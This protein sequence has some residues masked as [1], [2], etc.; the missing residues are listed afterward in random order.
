MEFG[1]AWWILFTTALVTLLI[2]DIARP[3]MHAR[4]A[5]TKSIFRVLLA[6]GFTLL[7]YCVKSPSIALDFFTGYLIEKSLSVDNLFVFLLIFTHLQVPK[8]LQHRI[9]MWGIFG[10]L[11]MRFIFIFAG[12]ALLQKLHFVL[13]LF[14]LFLVVTG[15]SMWK[16]RERKFSPDTNPLISFFK[17]CIPTT[18]DW[19]TE[20]F[21]VKKGGKLFATPLFSTLLAI[22]SADLVFALDSIPAVFAITLDPFIVFSCNALAILGLRSLYFV[23]QDLL[24]S[25]RLL[26]YGVCLI[27]IFVGTKMVISPFVAISSG[28]SLGVVATILVATLLLS[29]QIKQNDTKN[30]THA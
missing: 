18:D 27:L 25:F 20:R 29:T 4:Q 11:I 15:I 9:L 3:A 8:K 22:E 2:L 21:F 17:K 5:V 24:T 7:L 23:L 14:G 28:L 13:Y 1:I 16:K 10:A 30:D 19:A 12:I 6:V 26:H